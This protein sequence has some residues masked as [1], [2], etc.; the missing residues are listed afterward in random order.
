MCGMD[1]KSRMKQDGMRYGCIETRYGL[2]QLFSVQK[3]FQHKGDVDCLE[4]NCR[5][6]S[7]IRFLIINKDYNFVKLSVW[8]GY[9]VFFVITEENPV[10]TSFS[11][12][13][14]RRGAWVY[15][16]LNPFPHFENKLIFRFLECFFFLHEFGK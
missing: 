2:I 6:S 10:K 11:S 8:D 12:E 5:V 7:E 4:K 15:I 14:T 16:F 13:R 3:S 9:N 1:G